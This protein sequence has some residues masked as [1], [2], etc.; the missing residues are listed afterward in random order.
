MFLFSLWISEIPKQEETGETRVTAIS[1]MYNQSSYVCLLRGLT[2]KVTQMMRIAA[3]SFFLQL[4]ILLFITIENR[5]SPNRQEL[6]GQLNEG[7][8]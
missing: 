6:S 1:N 5:G 2:F 7:K 4:Y 8:E 3:F